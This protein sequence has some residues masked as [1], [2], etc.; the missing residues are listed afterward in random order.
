[1]RVINL[2]SG[3]HGN[4]TYIECG[5]HHILIDVGFSYREIKKRLLDA[6]VNIDDID[7]ILITH[8]HIDH[9][10][11]LREAIKHGKKIYLEEN[12]AKVLGMVN[13][14]Q[15]TII[16]DQ[17]F[18]IDEVRIKPFYLSHDSIS[19]LGY[20]IKCHDAVAAFVTDTGVL[21]DGIVTEIRD[22]KVVYIECNHD[23]E[24][25]METTYPYM[26]KKRIL[27]DIGHLS[28]S[29][30]GR[31]IVKLAYFGVKHF[32]LSH[33]SQHSNTKELA[34]HT[35]AQHIEAAGLKL[36]V[37]VIVRLTRQ[38]GKSN[39]FIIGE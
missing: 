9:V 7:T 21:P 28:N 35:V 23:E 3:S 24:M 4:C 37:D 30:C 27:S 39:N 16:R 18:N 6:G 14:A 32:V 12:C 22:S 8:E 10:K 38:D 36:G 34:C 29:Q 2:G 25:L 20:K 15:T 31:A 26:I 33:I 17:E 13:N 1:M 19:C 5:N 11:G